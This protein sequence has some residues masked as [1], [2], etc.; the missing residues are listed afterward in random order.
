MTN[1][2]QLTPISSNYKSILPKQIR[3]KSL[4]LKMKAWV[5]YRGGK[6]VLEEMP[7]PR[8]LPDDVLIEALWISI[9]ASDVNKFVGLVPGLIKTVFGHEFAGQ[10]V[11][12][13]ENVDKNLIGQ[14]VVVEEHY[15]CL[16][17]G[18]CKN[19]EFDR[20]ED[21]GFLGWYKSG[22][23]DDWVRNGAFAEYVS[24]HHSCAKPT[25]GIENLDF[26]P[27]LAEPFGNAVK[28]GS[29]IREKCNGMPETIAVWGGCGAQALYMV[30]YL[31]H[32]GVKNFILIY[33]GTPAKLYMQEMVKS[34]DSKFFFVHSS[35]LESLN[36]LK[37]SKTGDN[38]FVT[39]ELTGSSS[40]QDSAVQ[41]ASPGGKIFYYG[42]PAGGKTV[43]IPGTEIDIFSF[44]TGKSG[45]EQLSI[46]G[47][48][49]Y[50]VM[51]RNKKTWDTTIQVL[52][53]DKQLLEYINKPLVLAGTTENLGNLVRYLISNGVRYNQKPYG[54]RPAKFALVNDEM[55]L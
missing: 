51:G 7:I 38:G 5:T 1:N 43:Y 15:P 6:T 26:F 12:A 40:I 14:T 20:C 22:N 50:R 28:M 3:Q 45:F 24:I 32:S 2:L 13:G 54:P 29:I 21:E 27:S 44:I 16:Q 48:K 11:A 42:L 53:S 46:N 10:I 25:E 36:E 30:P 9:C 49:A 18:N 41:Y 37:K 35:D 33:K 17:C 4:P 47:V 34:L 52:K 8:M 23:P 31:A 55:M 19:G 39:I